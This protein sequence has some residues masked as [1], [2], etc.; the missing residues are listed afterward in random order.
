MTKLHCVNPRH[1][2]KHCAL[3]R[4]VYQQ[5]KVIKYYGNRSYLC[6]WLLKRNLGL[7]ADILQ[8]LQ[9]EHATDLYEVAGCLLRLAIWPTEKLWNALDVSLQPQFQS[10]LSAETSLQVG[11][12]FR[13]GDASFSE[14]ADAK[15]NPECFFDPAVPWKGTNFMDD[16]SLDSPLDEA[17]CGK[18]LLSAR[19]A[20]NNAQS[21]LPAEADALNRQIVAYIA[22]DNV[23]SSSQINS[24][25]GWEFTIRPPQGCHV[26]LQKSAHCTLSTS[27]HWFMLALSDHIVM[28]ALIK[29]AVS[30]FDNSP[31][32]AHLSAFEQPAPIS[33]FSR[34]AAIYSLATDSIR[35]GKGCLS[36]NRTALSQQTHGNW[37][38]DPRT[39]Y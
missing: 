1:S 11:F 19:V 30:M 32:T 13:C 21:R 17:S 34:Y 28:Q 14:K 39:F 7:S 18:Q 26:D 16:S 9:V 37:V 3:D 36:V 23:H 6:R 10:R 27:L 12:H 22:S 38:C 15:P 35:Y 8:H 33:A 29:P 20:A 2:S 5:Y 4:D 24:T 31:E 25:L